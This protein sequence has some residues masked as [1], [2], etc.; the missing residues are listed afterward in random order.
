MLSH[1]GNI[2]TLPW[3][4]VD[5]YIVKSDFGVTRN[6][7][8]MFSPKLVTLVGEALTRANPD[9]LDL[10]VG[11]ALQH[12]VIAPRAHVLA[13]HRP[14]LWATERKKAENEASGRLIWMN[15]STE[16]P[17]PTPP[18]TTLPT[19]RLRGVIHLVMS[20]LALV[21]GLTLVTLA[22]TFRGR[23]AG[24]LYTL[25][26][27]LLFTC[28]ALYH[29]GKWSPEVKAVW[30]RIDHANIPI[31]IAG[32][33]T[34]FALFLLTKTSSIVMLCVVWGGAIAAAVFRVLWMNAP[35]WLY[36][37][38]YIALGWVAVIYMPTFWQRGGVLVCVLII[39]GGVLYSVGGIF[40]ALKKPNISIKWFGFHELFHALT[41]AAFIVP[42]IAALLVI[43]SP[44]V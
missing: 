21:A 16:K 40:Y 42:F 6:D 19:P 15:T 1:D 4:K 43:L 29:R 25:T 17:T 27:V 36:V 5:R 28:S 41:A 20:P 23:I 18:D 33:Y 32:T 26:A 37:P 8:P 7:Q 10:M 3:P 39:L 44:P 11:G 14:T 31:L 24:A 22:A 13:H 2:D 30:R 9:T 12:L 35:R 34:P 38:V